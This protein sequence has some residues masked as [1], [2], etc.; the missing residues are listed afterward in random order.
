MMKRNI[1]AALIP[2]LLAAGAANAVELYNKDGTKV[3]LKGKIDARHLFSR[4]SKEAGDKSSFVFDAKAESKITDQLTGYGRWKYNV[5]LGNSEGSG[6]TPINLMNNKDNAFKKSVS[7]QLGVNKGNATELAFLGMKFGEFNAIEYGRNNG[8]IHDINAWTDVRP[9]FSSGSL[10]RSDNFMTGRGTDL[11]TYR[12]TDFFGLVDGLNF[13]LQYQGKNDRDEIQE[14]NGVGIGISSTYDT[15]YG[16]SFGAAYSIAQRTP[17]QINGS[18]SMVKTHSPVAMPSKR[19]NKTSKT[20]AKIGNKNELTA[21]GAANNAT[22]WNVA[23]KYDENNVYLAAMY[24]QT[25][26]TT[27]F[28]SKGIAARKTSDIEF[29]AMYKFDF[30][31]NP[32]IGYVQSI[33]KDLIEHKDIIDK[34]ASCNHDLVKYIA[35][36]TSY[37]FNKNIQTYVDYKINLLDKDKFTD[38]QGLGTENIIGAGFSYKF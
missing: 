24:A 7:S 17:G 16:V 13:N 30:G 20:L 32:S 37:D 27:P 33:G 23:A 38:N 5:G 31:L 18:N 1:L 25:N 36:G 2:A 15:G 34:K 8:V 6:V 22:A 26:N 9:V 14:S 21:I 29:T 3:E 4:D 35:V 10:S 19:L 12:N 11:S 28:G